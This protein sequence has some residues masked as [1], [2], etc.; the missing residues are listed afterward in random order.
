MDINSQKTTTV[1]IASLLT[2]AAVLVTAYSLLT[3]TRGGVA[4][5]QEEGFT[6]DVAIDSVSWTQ[7][8]SKLQLTSQ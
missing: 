5:A 3:T 8:L 7:G 6:L 4:Y 1:S 2:A